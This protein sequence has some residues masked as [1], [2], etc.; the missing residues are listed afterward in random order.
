MDL[1][2]TAV[3]RDD[4]GTVGGLV[5]VVVGVQPGLRQIRR[6]H[7]VDAGAGLHLVGAGLERD[8]RS[9]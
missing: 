4:D 5:A 1:Q 6:D 8:L 9:L 7:V 2:R 3:S